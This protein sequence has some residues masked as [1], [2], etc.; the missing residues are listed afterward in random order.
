MICDPSVQVPQYSR[1]LES[2]NLI[3]FMISRKG[4]VLLIHDQYLYR[5]NMKRQGRDKNVIYW[6]CVLNRRTKCRGRVKSVD[7]IIYPTNTQGNLFQPFL[8]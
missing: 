6:E 2:R 1:T 3:P 7:N 5:S 4:G 8:K